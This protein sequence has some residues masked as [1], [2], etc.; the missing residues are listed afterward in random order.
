MAERARASAPAIQPRLRG[1][2][3]PAAP[4]ATSGAASAGAPL[5]P[6]HEADEVDT[7][8]EDV[9]ALSPGRRMEPAGAERVTRQDRTRAPIAAPLPP[10]E[11]TPHAARRDVVPPAPGRESTR[12]ESPVEPVMEPARSGEGAG[13]PPGAAWPH[14]RSAAPSLEPHAHAVRSGEPAARDGAAQPGATGPGPVQP[15]PVQ[16]AAFEQPPLGGPARGPSTIQPAPMPPESVTS[17]PAALAARGQGLLVPGPVR[18]SP[19]ISPLVAPP[20]APIVPTTRAGV[21]AAPA[22]PGAVAAPGANAAPAPAP[23]IHVTI[24]RVEVRA[25]APSTPQRKA[26]PAPAVMSLDEYLDRNAGGRR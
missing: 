24:G 1:R 20:I 7:L 3:E 5:P 21:P 4:V 16:R 15:G 11:V 10:F 18:V 9:Q 22:V 14:A 23:T 13:Q 25:T 6:G 19:P 17:E 26:R 8:D 2:F 12:T